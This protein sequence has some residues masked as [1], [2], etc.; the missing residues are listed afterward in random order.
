[1][2]QN[3][4]T[5]ATFN[6]GGGSG[7]CV[8]NDT[9][10][11]LNGGR[12]RITATYDTGAQNGNA[13]TV[14]L[15][16]ETGYLWFFNSVNVEVVVKVINACSLNQRFWVYAGGLTDQGVVFTVTDTNNGAS[17]TYTNLRGQKWV[18]ITDSSAL[19]TCP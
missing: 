10:L 9:T 12:F 14:K 6:L 4:S 18:T 7:P 2:T 8:P 15:T 16:D 5:T 3:Q 11:C 19:A 13:H 1:M 17:K